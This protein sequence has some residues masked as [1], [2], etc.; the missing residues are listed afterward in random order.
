M[1]QKR[2]TGQA[3]LDLTKK[4]KGAPLSQILDEAGFY[5]MRDGQKT[6]NRLDYFRET[7]KAQGMDFEDDVSSGGSGRE[8]S[9]EL[10]VGSKGTIPLGHSYT[11]LI[12]LEPGDYASIEHVE[13]GKTFKAGPE[14]AI[15]LFPAPP[16]E[17]V[18]PQSASLK[19]VA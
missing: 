14:G 6:Y 2:I 15:V 4:M 8:P 9:F 7:A 1:S 18:A 5:T 12:G 13:A 11:C 19:A 3:L 16:E 10:K 17:N